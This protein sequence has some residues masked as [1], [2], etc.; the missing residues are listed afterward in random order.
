MANEIDRCARKREPDHSF[1]RA[2]DDAGTDVRR[3]LAQR[4]NEETRR[5]AKNYESQVLKL[6]QAVA[7]IFQHDRR[8][9]HRAKNLDLCSEGRCGQE[10]EAQ[11]MAAGPLRTPAWR[12]GRL[13]RGSPSAVARWCSAALDSPSALRQAERRAS[14][15]GGAN[16]SRALQA[17]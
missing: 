8:A 9:G 16:P 15:A 2:R 17:S 3:I 1:H 13:G 10:V 14:G 6:L 11:V 4:R 12:G 5:N 7:Q